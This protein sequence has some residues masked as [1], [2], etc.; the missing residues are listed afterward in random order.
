MPE[1]LANA[2]WLPDPTEFTLPD[3]DAMLLKA[4]LKFEK[5]SELN[6][7]AQHRWSDSAYIRKICSMTGFRVVYDAGATT[8]SQQL[9]FNNAVTCFVHGQGKSCPSNNLEQD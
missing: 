3:P 9:D 2:P 7:N 4:V 1:P 8:S 5:K 6:C